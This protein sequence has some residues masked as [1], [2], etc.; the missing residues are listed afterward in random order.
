MPA[1]S[2]E[3]RVGTTCPDENITLDGDQD[4]ADLTFTFPTTKLGKFAL[5]TFNINYHP[6]DN[7]KDLAFRISH[8]GAIVVSQTTAGA[9]T[10]GQNGITI[11]Y[12]APIVATQIIKAVV[13]LDGGTNTLADVDIF[14]TGGAGPVSFMQVLE[15]P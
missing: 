14:G 3:N 7:D 1:K 13:A 4:I 10:N 15:L 8:N 9:K 6:S 12:I 5:V 2:R 11:T